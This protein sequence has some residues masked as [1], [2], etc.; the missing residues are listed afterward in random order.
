MEISSASSQALS[1][2]EQLN[3][4]QLGVA[5]IKQAAESE[6]K[7]ANMLA[8]NSK[9]IQAPPSAEPGGFSTYA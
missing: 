9:T 2:K 1:L 6:E 3:S 5:A 8:Q 4:T 7:M